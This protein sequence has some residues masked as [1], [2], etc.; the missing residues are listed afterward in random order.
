VGGRQRRLFREPSSP[1]GLTDER[2]EHAD[3]ANCKG[4]IAMADDLLIAMIIAGFGLSG[5]YFRAVFVSWRRNQAAERK[6]EISLRELYAHRLCSD[7]N[8]V[9]GS[10]TVQA[11]KNVDAKAA[12]L[13][14]ITD[15]EPRPA[16][17]RVSRCSERQSD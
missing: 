17:D 13:G 6:R 11:E 10:S 2:P 14:A 5:A 12:T 9:P 3:F 1:P 7:E 4:M 8:D 16:I 15:G